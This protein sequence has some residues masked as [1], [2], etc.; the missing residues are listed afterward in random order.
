MLFSHASYFCSSRL[1]PASCW[2]LDMEGYR[3]GFCV[4]LQ[5][6]IM[7]AP[8]SSRFSCSSWCGTLYGKS[9]ESNAGLCSFAFST[10]LFLAQLDCLRCELANEHRG[11]LVRRCCLR[12]EWFRS[13]SATTLHC[14]SSTL[15]ILKLLSLQFAY[16]KHIDRTHHR[17]RQPVLGAAWQPWKSLKKQ[18]CNLFI[19]PFRCMSQ[20]TAGILEN[21]KQ[22]LLIHGK[23]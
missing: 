10:T 23:R 6:A 20:F 8:H 7:S 1:C 18:L 4:P 2:P 12:E 9:P 17:Q 13:L 16:H 15:A 5:M 3:T 14:C 19:Y 11:S 21:F 22:L